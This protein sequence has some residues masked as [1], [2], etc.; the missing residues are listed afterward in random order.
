MINNSGNT[1]EP[2]LTTGNIRK[3][4]VNSAVDLNGV[5]FI[6]LTFLHSRLIGIDVNYQETEAIRSSEELE[7]R[8]SEELHLPLFSSHTIECYDFRVRTLAVDSLTDRL[9]LASVTFT[10]VAAQKLLTDRREV[11]KQRVQRKKL[12]QEEQ[13]KKAFKL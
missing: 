2:G 13:R 3:N 5:D 9:W 12:E 1:G 6:H 4:E 8:I 10:E 7:S 11:D